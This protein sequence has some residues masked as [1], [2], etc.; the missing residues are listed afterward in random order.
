MSGVT[1][2][3]F[4]RIA[5]DLGAGLVIT[6]MVASEHLVRQRHGAR[7]RAVGRNLAPFVIQLAGCEARWMA[8]GARIASRQ[9]W[10]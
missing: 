1:D 8:E 2:L 10:K 4:R 6:E 9:F 7:E 3:A 5:H